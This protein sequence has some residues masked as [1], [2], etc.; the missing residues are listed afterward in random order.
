[1]ETQ[2]GSA[3]N[4]LFPLG[5]KSGAGFERSD[6]VFPIR[7]PVGFLRLSLLFGAPRAI[8]LVKIRIFGELKPAPDYFLGI[9]GN[10]SPGPGARRVHGPHRARVRSRECS[11]ES[12]FRAYETPPT[13]P[14][15]LSSSSSCWCFEL[16]RECRRPV[17]G[18]TRR[19]RTAPDR[20][21]G[22]RSSPARC[23]S[24]RRNTGDDSSPLRRRSP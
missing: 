16:N 22:R 15:T 20:N 5:C 23:S 18:G 9:M 10:I 6:N 19:V 4:H 8:F 11:R 13:A 1:M 17:L 7:F 12:L 14:L 24:H 2:G 3:R 21:P